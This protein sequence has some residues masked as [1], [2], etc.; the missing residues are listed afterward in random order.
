MVQATGERTAPSVAGVCVANGCAG[1]AQP[2]S[3]QKTA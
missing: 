1:M 3:P 2:I